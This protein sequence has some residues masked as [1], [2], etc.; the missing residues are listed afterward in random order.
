MNDWQRIEELFHRASQL[1]VHEADALLDREC[2]DPAARQELERLLAAHRK[3]AGF[4]E[5]RRLAQ[6]L[7][8][9][10]DLP[11]GTYIGGYRIVA[12]LGQGGMGAVYLAEGST[13]VAIKIAASVATGELAQRLQRERELLALLDHPNIAR[14][15]GGGTTDEGT[16]YFVM[17][18][19]DGAPIDRWC[20]ERTVALRGRVELV[21]AVAAAVVYAHERHIVHR[22]L[23]PANILVTT[24]GAPKLL[25]FGIAKAFDPDVLGVSVTTLGRRA[26]TPEYAS[27]EQLSGAPITMASDIYSLGVVLYELVAG[28]SPHSGTSLAALLESIAIRSPAPATGGEDPVLDAILATALQKHPAA[29]H[30]SML[31]LHDELA[32]W[33]AERH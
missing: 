20:R 4:L 8:S 13:K 7:E 29:R 21:R 10:A 17:E 3:S 1:A 31:Q 6:W 14:L 22:D 23:K 24:D 27:P 5:N 16:P 19:V 9:I 25:D 12:P 26:M 15:E 2:S 18:Y 33:L 28:R 11:A 30:P 32:G